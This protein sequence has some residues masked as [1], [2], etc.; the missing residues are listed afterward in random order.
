MLKS[1]STTDEVFRMCL[2]YVL[3]TRKYKLFHLSVRNGD[4]ILVEYLYEYFIPIWLMTSKHNYV[5]IALNQIED[6]YGRVP[7]HV[8]Q[9]ARENRMQPIHVG[10]D[11]NGTPMAQW[12]LDALMEL[13]QIK[14]KAMN[15]PNSREGW[16]KHSTNMPLVARSKIFCQTEYSRRYDVE[17]Y[18]EQFF[19]FEAAGEKQ[20]KGNN[21]TPTQ[22]PRRNQEKVMVAEILHLSDAFTETENRKMTV[23]TFWSVLKDVTT[24]LGDDGEKDSEGLTSTD[25]RSQGELA[26]VEVNHEMMHNSPLQNETTEEVANANEMDQLA[27]FQQL[28]DEDNALLEADM[29]EEEDNN[30]ETIDNPGDGERSTMEATRPRGRLDES[31]LMVDD[32]ET[33]IV[34]GINEKRIKVQMTQFNRMGLCNVYEDGR[35]KMKKMKIPDIRFRQRCRIKRE[36]ATLQAELNSYLNNKDGMSKTISLIEKLRQG[37]TVVTCDNRMEYKLMKKGMWVVPF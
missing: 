29:E 27:W 18:D 1:K 17:S 12:A 31:C 2:H 14:Y 25:G 8:L 30:N 33:E 4:S 22:A 24:I 3:L 13:L 34:I 11:R 32:R 20:D 23:N 9:A 5:E 7:F 28:E 10:V 35:L 16:Q 15:F 6:L 19:E 36:I 37:G 26:L 21:K